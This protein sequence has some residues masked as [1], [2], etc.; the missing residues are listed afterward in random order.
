MKEGIYE[1]GVGSGGRVEIRGRFGIRGWISL[2]TLRFAYGGNVPWM[3]LSYPAHIGQVPAESEMTDEQRTLKAK[4]TS[5]DANGDGSLDVVEFGAFVHPQRHDHMVQHLVQDQLHTYDKNG[6]SEIGR[7]EFLG[8]RGGGDRAHLGRRGGG[9]R[10][11]LGRR[12]GGDRVHL[13]RRGGG[14]RAHLGR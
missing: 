6:D 7:K 4:F 13:G 12:R 5:A 9:D 2:T 8:R 14:D 1:W 11:H 10:A 3:I